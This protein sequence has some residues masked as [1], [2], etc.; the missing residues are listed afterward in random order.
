[1]LVTDWLAKDGCIAQCLPGF[2]ARP[3]QVEMAAAV[4]R[5]FETP[6]HLAVEAGTGVGKTF[7][8]LLP[9]IEQIVQHQRRVV[10]STHTIALQEQLIHKDVP[11]LQKALGENFRAELVKGRTNYLSLR[12]L[13]GAS[14][15]QRS[16]L[17]SPRLRNALHAVEDWA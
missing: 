5:A 11:F 1:M 16:L 17:P 15:K 8:Y 13:K 12:R 9:A 3:Q 6:R 7:A 10:V 4:A 14:E 2:E